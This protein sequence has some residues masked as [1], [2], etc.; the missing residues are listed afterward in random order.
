MS[1]RWNIFINSLMIYIAA[2]MPSTF[3][4]ELGHAISSFIFNGSPILHHNYVAHLTPENMTSTENLIVM[5]AGPLASLFKGLLAGVLFLKYKKYNL[6]SLFLLWL[7]IFGLNNFL[8]YF[9]TGP[10]FTEG[11]IGKIYLLYNVPTSVQ[12]VISVISAGLLLLL[13]YKL[14]VPFLLFSYKNQW[15]ANGQNRKNFSLKI[16]ILPWIFGS[17]FVTL[18]YLPIV[19]FVSI[20][21]PFMSGFIFIYP[22]QNANQIERVPISENRQIGK[23][24]FPVLIVLI[25]LILIFRLLLAPGIEL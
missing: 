19:A 11:D 25:I 1:E 24:S 15:V 2:F 22:W 14:T 8:G 12:I 18:L 7:A 23:F 13:A 17:V 10:F 20:V 21:Y 9:L 16:L 4:H 6:L 3:L 5:L